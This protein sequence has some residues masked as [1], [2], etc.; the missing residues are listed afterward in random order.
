M[1]SPRPGTPAAK[2]KHVDREIAKKRLIIFKKF[3]D[4]I[5]SNIKKVF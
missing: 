3:A 4:K 1:F 2:L 5:K